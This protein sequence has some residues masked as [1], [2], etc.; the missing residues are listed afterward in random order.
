MK[1]QVYNT[2]LKCSGCVAKVKDGLDALVKVKWEV[3]LN[4]MPRRLIVEAEEDMTDQIKAVLQAQGF[5]AE[6]V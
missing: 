4:V 6:K 3:D 5:E 1:K 2:T